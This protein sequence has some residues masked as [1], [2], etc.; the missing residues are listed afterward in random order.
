MA[1]WADIFVQNYR[2]SLY[3]SIAS[4]IIASS[5][6]RTS[7]SLSSSATPNFNFNCVMSHFLAATFAAVFQMILPFYLYSFLNS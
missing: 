1:S 7:L 4:L 3:T 6:S 5:C 2:N